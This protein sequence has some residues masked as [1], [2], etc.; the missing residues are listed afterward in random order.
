MN[1][2]VEALRLKNDPS[3]TAIATVPASHLGSP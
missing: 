3:P 2:L 1:I